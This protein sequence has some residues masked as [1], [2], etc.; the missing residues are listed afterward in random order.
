[1]I[2]RLLLAAALA[3]LSSTVPAAAQDVTASDTSAAVKETDATPTATRPEVVPLTP[4]LAS[5][6]TASSWQTEGR[7]CEGC[8]PRSV[9]RALAQTTIVNGFYELANLIRGQV[10]AHITPK[11]WW[12]NMQ[13]GW[14]WDLDDFAVNQVGHPYQGNNYF[15]TGRA[16]GLNFWESSAVTA[17]GSATW[18]YYGETNHASLNDLINTT[19]GGIALGE[20][21]HRTAWLIRDPQ[22]T[23]RGRLWREIGATVVDPITGAN[24]F[25]RGDASRVAAKPADMVPSSLTAM[26]SAGALWRGTE[27]SAFTASGQAFLEI[28]GLYGDLVTGHS[29]T[30]YDAFAVRLR[31]GGGSAFSEARVRGRLVGQPLR[32]GALQFDVLQ[33]YDYQNN[34]AY[35]T[36]SQ[37]FDAALAFGTSAASRTRL[38]VLGWGGLTVLG[39]IDSLPLGLTEKP[40]EGEGNAGQ[41]V[42]E[43][44]R[45]YDYGPGANFGVTAALTRGAYRP[46]A[47][48]YDGRHLYSLDGVRANHFLQRVRLDLLLPLHRP[49]G[50]GA[51]AEYFNRRT[52]Y[53][54]VNRTVVGYAYPQLRGY[55][56]WEP[57]ATRGSTTPSAAS[58]ASDIRQGSGAASDLWFTAG[59]TFS[60]LRGD[61]QTCET[62]TP[63]RHSGGLVGDLGY[64][65]NNRM[66]V[67]GEVFW[68]PV[69][70]A[71]GNVRATHFDAVA[72]FR[73]WSSQGFFVKGGAGMAL[74]RNWV[75][76]FG[77]NAFNS[78]ALSV[79]IG[80]GWAFR[81]ADRIGLQLFGTQHASA[82]GDFETVAA[83]VQ[84]VVGNYWSLGASIIIR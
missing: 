52:Y 45:Y 37:S 31:F 64:R 24:R 3:V 27:S 69:D 41:G 83:T 62:D 35:Q 50:I 44:P 19:L 33:T 28:D 5:E 73:P 84:D 66:D 10:T 81:P 6:T 75:D 47:F 51:S 74:I 15:N 22:A 79:V 9:G 71:D 30:P 55:F 1:M 68:M 11:T 46:L 16:N 18:E 26:A 60:T 80:A 58:A 34:D 82:I 53:Q 2:S 56:T 77:A 76:A 70:T 38:Q 40:E 67:G 8:P 78:K 54:D 13:Q 12:A 29:R 39:A 48:S 63:Y 14:V 23:G 61:C 36:G 57:G 49:F 32:N 42:S 17:F 21:F 59:G 65:V 20:M 25:L 4:A 72:Q 7:A 43:G